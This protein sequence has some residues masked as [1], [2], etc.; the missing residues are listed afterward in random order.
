MAPRVGFGTEDRDKENA[1]KLAKGMVFIGAEDDCAAATSA[2]ESPRVSTSR[3]TRGQ[4]QL[5]V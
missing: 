1:P 5:A 4:A 3:A 2:L